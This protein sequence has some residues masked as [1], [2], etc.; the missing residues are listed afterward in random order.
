MFPTRSERLYSICFLR[1]LSNN[2][3][4]VQYFLG[5]SL[6][7]QMILNKIVPFVKVV[8]RLG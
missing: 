8:M 3:V 6:K 4:E 7:A 2:F 5:W 1:C